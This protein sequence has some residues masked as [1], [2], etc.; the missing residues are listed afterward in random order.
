MVHD[1]A[2]K[3]LPVLGGLCTYHDSTGAFGGLRSRLPGNQS[4][5]LEAKKKVT[6]ATSPIPTEAPDKPGLGLIWAS[7]WDRAGL[8]GETFEACSK[9]A[10]YQL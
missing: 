9:P 2:L 10:L 8:E 6:P 4:Q 3:G 7:F 1:R 5:L